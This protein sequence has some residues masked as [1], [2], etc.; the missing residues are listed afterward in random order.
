MSDPGALPELAWLPVDKLDV[1]PAYQRTLDTKASQKLIQKIADGFRWIS[2]Q[3]ILATPVGKGDD[4]RWL[5]IDGQH[6]VA[7]ARLCE[8]EHVPAVVVAEASQSEQA[9]AFVGANRNR[10]PM[11]AQALYHAELAAGEPEALT[12]A[13]LAAAAGI[14]IVRHNLAARPISFSPN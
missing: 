14:A 1:D 12:I 11:S 4:K 6:R 7:A 10:V 3:A 9:A 5:V 8:I 2:F 13:R